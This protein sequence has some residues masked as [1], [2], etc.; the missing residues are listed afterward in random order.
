MICA[1]QSFQ[2]MASR[3]DAALLEVTHDLGDKLAGEVR[4]Q[5]INANDD[6]NKKLSAGERA[7][8]ARKARALYQALKSAIE[9]AG[10]QKSEVLATLKAELG[11]RF[12]TDPAWVSDST[13]QDIVRVA[14][15][16]AVPQ[17][18]VRRT[19]SG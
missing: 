6:F 18:E 10:W 1:A 16:I 14:P 13:P 8:A 3:D 11:S 7:D 17:P 4:E 15:A 5:L 12:P 9:A 19:N 2:K